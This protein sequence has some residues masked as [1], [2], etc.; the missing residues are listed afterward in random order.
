MRAR[1][2]RAPALPSTR[3]QFTSRAATE[4]DE[5]QICIHATDGGRQS[6]GLGWAPTLTF[7][8]ITHADL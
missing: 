1:I 2:S 7:F 8:A 6:I 5:P 3:R 4:R